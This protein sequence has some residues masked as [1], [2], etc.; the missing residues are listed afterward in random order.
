M[1][2]DILISHIKFKYEGFREECKI[3]LGEEPA[4]DEI[5]LYSNQ[6]TSN[7]PFW[8]GDCTSCILNG[9]TCKYPN[10]LTQ[11]CQKKIVELWWERIM[12]LPSSTANMCMHHLGANLNNVDEACYN[13]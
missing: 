10:A 2:I 6:Y 5:H 1:V 4:V 8:G 9:K 7:Q 13:K 3:V 12:Q 11:P